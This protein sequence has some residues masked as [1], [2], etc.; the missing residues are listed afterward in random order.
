M[1][2]LYFYTFQKSLEICISVFF[3]ADKN[4]TQEVYKKKNYKYLSYTY[5]KFIRHC[6]FKN[7][8]NRFS[9]AAWH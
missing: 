8:H 1:T 6:V 5:S 3:N 4:T 2:K 7:V 9:Y